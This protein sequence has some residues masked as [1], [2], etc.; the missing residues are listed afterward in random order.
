MFVG[1]W[2]LECACRGLST[3]CKE[4]LLQKKEPVTL[5]GKAGCLLLHPPVRREIAWRRTVSSDLT[6]PRANTEDLSGCRSS[7][8]AVFVAIFW[9]RHSPERESYAQQLEPSRRSW[10][11]GPMIAERNDAICTIWDDLR[12]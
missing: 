1:I 8:R 2:N 11:K 5:L 9:R 3:F 7:T 12:A 4:P 10:E 6:Q